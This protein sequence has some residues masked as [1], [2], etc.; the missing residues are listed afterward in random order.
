MSSCQSWSHLSTS[1]MGPVYEPPPLKG[2]VKPATKNIGTQFGAHGMW[3]SSSQPTIQQSACH[4]AVP[5]AGIGGHLVP[6]F[7]SHTKINFSHRETVAKCT[8]HRYPTTQ[9]QA[10]GS[11]IQSL[12]I[13]AGQTTCVS[14]VQTV[15][16]SKGKDSA[17]LPVGDIKD[18]VFK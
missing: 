2:E 6:D 5:S 3:T 15:P 12:S 14:S 13:H 8:F 18:S 7:R 11:S 4:P 17:H 9:L 10:A 16:V 1:T